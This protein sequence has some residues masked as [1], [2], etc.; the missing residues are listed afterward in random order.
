MSNNRKNRLAWNPVRLKY[1]ALTRKT[2]E[3][4]TESDFARLD[5]EL[6]KRILSLHIVLSRAV[7]DLGF[8]K[9]IYSKCNLFR[10]D[11]KET[12]EKAI[13]WGNKAIDMVTLEPTEDGAD[14]MIRNW[15]QVESAIDDAVDYALGDKYYTLGKENDLDIQFKA[16]FAPHPVIY[17]VEGVQLWED[18]YAK[19]AMD[20][21]GRKTDF[22]FTTDDGGTLTISGQEL[23]D[24]FV[25]Y[26][27]EHGGVPSDIICYKRDGNGM[28]KELK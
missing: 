25:K 4:V 22:H 2:K 23:G 15:E 17:T 5:N 9:G 3:T 28:S 26:C 24:W 21:R 16:K 12:Y 8:I 11:I 14:K 13:N 10:G 6:R 1:D 19:G 20:E 18:G 7:D 27:K